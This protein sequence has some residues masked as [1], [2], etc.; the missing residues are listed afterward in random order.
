LW[1]VEIQ[2]EGRKSPM[3]EYAQTA[4]VEM[5]TRSASGPDLAG[6]LGPLAGQRPVLDALIEGLGPVVSTLVQVTLGLGGRT[7]AGTVSLG[8]AE[9]ELRTQG[10]DLMRAVLQAVMDAASAGQER[11]PGGVSGPGGVRRTRIED[12]HTRA[13][14]TVFGRI[15]VSRLAYRAPGVA[16]VH[17][18]DEILDLPGGLYSARIHRVSSA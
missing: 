15:T 3:E 8:Q 12:G 4:L 6:A 7:A 9:E 18:L 1:V 5:L 10:R 17:P 2:N 11:V 13:V 14:A 16:N